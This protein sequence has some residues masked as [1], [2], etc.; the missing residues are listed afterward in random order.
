MKKALR[1]TAKN[2]GSRQV[3]IYQRTLLAAL[4]ALRDG[5]FVPGSISHD[6]LRPGLRFLHVAREGYR[7]R[8]M[9]IYCPVGGKTIQVLRILHDASDVGRHL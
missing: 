2:F 6:E 3:P 5:P 9:I 7:G 8:H 1:D 4:E